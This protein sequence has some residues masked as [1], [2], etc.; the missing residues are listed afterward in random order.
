MD[1]SS[2]YITSTL[3]QAESDFG[4]MK[5]KAAIDAVKRAG[6]EPG[7]NARQVA[8][9]FEAVFLNTM[10]ESMFASVKMDGP[11]DGGYGGSVYRSML[12]EQYAKAIAKSGGIGIADK[13]YQ[14]ILQL[15]EQQKQPASPPKE[16]D[17][18]SRR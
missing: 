18:A 16:L 10:V 14:Q 6:I 1:F 3:T 7:Q 11:F 13:I 9:D 4:Q 15:Q 12:N 2:Q 5:Q 8:E 17:H